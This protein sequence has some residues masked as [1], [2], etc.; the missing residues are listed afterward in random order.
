MD[1]RSIAAEIL[2]HVT[3]I[4]KKI[5]DVAEIARVLE[6]DGMAEFVHAGQIDDAVTKELILTRTPGNVFA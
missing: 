6:P 4:T 1:L 2:G 3:A 5:H